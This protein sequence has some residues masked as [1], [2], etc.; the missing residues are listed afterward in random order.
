MNKLLKGSIAGAAGIALLMGG[1]GTFA[2][3]ND[4]ATLTGGTVTAGT[5]TATAV[6]GGTVTVKHGIA[7]TAVPLT[8]TF[9]I[10]PGDI[11]TYTQNVAINASGDNLNASWALTSTLAAAS[12]A[13]ADAQLKSF[14][15]T[16][17]V[18]AVDSTTLLPIP[19]TLPAGATTAKVTA[20]LTFPNGVAGAENLA[21][22]GAVTL[23]N[24]GL[25]VTQG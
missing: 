23:S 19:A 7:G 5:L 9:K 17:V 24:L 21:K 15:N 14:I 20:V 1:A 4:A 11:V 10:V 22:T 6:A 13:A 16:A 8:P 12:G 2:L 18:T 25:T 3:W